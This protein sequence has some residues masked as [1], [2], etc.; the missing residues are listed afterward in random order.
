LHG[1]HTSIINTQAPASVG[2]VDI[3]CTL[4]I[5]KI[6]GGPAYGRESNPFPEF[7]ESQLPRLTGDLERVVYNRRIMLIGS[8]HRILDAFDVDTE[9]DDDRPTIKRRDD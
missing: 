8:S 1:I 5:R 3:L 7:R 6:D 4:R 9:E 2:S